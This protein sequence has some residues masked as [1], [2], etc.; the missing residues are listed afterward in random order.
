MKASSRTVQLPAMPAT[1]SKP[2]GL[3]E[4][5][6]CV[7]LV[8]SVES[9]GHSVCQGAHVSLSGACRDTKV[10]EVCIHCDECDFICLGF[11]ESAFMN[12]NNVFVF[13]R[14][15]CISKRSEGMNIHSMSVSLGCGMEQV[16]GMCTRLT[17]VRN[18][19]V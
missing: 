17:L 11:R 16:R 5:Q 14:S 9:A 1:L 4:K 2:N 7:W 6:R 18:I 3:S 12:E 8:H 10:E 15:H 19:C 13:L